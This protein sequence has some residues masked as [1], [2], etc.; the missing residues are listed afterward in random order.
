MEV[1]APVN[2]TLTIAAKHLT[3]GKMSYLTIVSCLIFV[4]ECS[5][6]DIMRELK[7]NILN[8]GYGVNFKYE[9]M[10]SHLFD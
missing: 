5:G 3:K 8:F 2:I 9:G 6:V 10:L 7:Q 4:Y 1:N